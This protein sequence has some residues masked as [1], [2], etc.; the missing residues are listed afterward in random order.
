MQVGQAVSNRICA[1]PGCPEPTNAKHC[2]QHAREADKAR[3][4]REQRGYGTAHQRE[5]AA[6][7][8]ALSQGPLTCWRCGQPIYRASDLH[9]GHDGNRRTMGPEH[10]ACNLSAAGR[11]RHGR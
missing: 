3:G 8:R 6:A 1:K 10:A 7:I 5:R 2:E 9:I 4:S 11:A